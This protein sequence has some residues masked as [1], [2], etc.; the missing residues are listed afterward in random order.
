LGKFYQGVGEE[1][2]LAVRSLAWLNAVP[3][4]PKET[5]AKDRDTRT[6]RE[7]MESEGE[8]V[9]VPDC[10]APFLVARLFEIGPVVAGGMGP[11]PI[12]WRDVEAWQNC[13]GVRMPPWQCRTMVELSREYLSFAIEA[14]KRDCAAPWSDE[15]MTENRRERI[16]RQL[17]AGLRAMMFRPSI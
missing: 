7:R 10:S 3:D 14:R 8:E 13:S 5:L 15:A 9:T 1:L 6:R 12:G 17:K 16:S 4:G 2:T 11:A